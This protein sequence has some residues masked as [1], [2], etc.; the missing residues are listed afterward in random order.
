MT[1]RRAV[2]SCSLSRCVAP[3]KHTIE[4][5]RH[6][7]ITIR[8]RQHIGFLCAL[9]NHNSVLG[10]ESIRGALACSSLPAHVL[11]MF[12]IP[13]KYVS[14]II[15]SYGCLCAFLAVPCLHQEQPSTANDQRNLAWWR[16]CQS[17][18][19]KHVSATL[20]ARATNTGTTSRLG[21]YKAVHLHHSHHENERR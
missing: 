17:H 4:I 2:P 14:E 12:C 19:K 21:H 11:L 9:A 7:L 3:A 6:N 8:V 13:A 5:D 15:Y 20:D 18:R 1:P 10:L 16:K